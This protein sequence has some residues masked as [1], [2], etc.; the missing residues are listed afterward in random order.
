MLLLL[1]VLLVAD[2]GLASGVAAFNGSS[3]S[4]P[5]VT[6]APT[7]AVGARTGYTSCY[8]GRPRAGSPRRR[9]HHHAIVFPSD[10]KLTGLTSTSLTDTTAAKLVGQANAT[11]L[12]V[13]YF[14]YTGAV[15]AAGDTLS[16]S[17]QGAT[18]PTSPG[19][20]YKVAV[21]TSS[22]T[23]A[24]NCS[25]YT[26]VAGHSVST[27]A[28][29]LA[30]TSA[31]GGRTGY[32]VAFNVSSTG[33]LSQAAGSTITITFPSDSKAN[34]LTSTALNDVTTA[35][36]I[37]QANATGPLTVVFFL[38]SGSVVNAGDSLS[39]SI[40]GVVNPTSASATYKLTVSTTSDTPA[41]NSGN[42]AVVA[43][44]SISTPSVTLSPTSAAGGRLPTRWRSTSH[45]PAAS[46]RR[47][48][49]PS[50]SRS[51]QTARRT[52]LAG[53]P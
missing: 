15:V 50:P 41:V 2:I 26:I 45:P 42:Y 23:T 52:R 29:T 17:V 20:T 8:N 19:T 9:Q 11:G 35:K 51:R 43:A 49:A 28:V 48:A 39:S 3:V 53:P 1:A 31:A 21:S 34:S 7:A 33:G 30:P 14:L 5:T 36:L 47:P 25:S 44:H 12:T 6:L 13:T 37:G 4:V 16:A 24:V 18:N 40:Q 22:D 10:T 38:Y 27:P 46:P 32:T